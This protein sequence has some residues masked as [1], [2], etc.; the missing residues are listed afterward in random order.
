MNYS[1]FMKHESF[2][3]RMNEEQR[4]EIRVLAG[5]KFTR[6]HIPNPVNN[7]GRWAEIWGWSAVSVWLTLL[8]PRKCV[9]E[10]GP[11]GDRRRDDE[12]KSFSEFRNSLSLSCQED[13]KPALLQ[14]TC[15]KRPPWHCY[16]IV[17]GDP[18][19]NVAGRGLLQQLHHALHGLE[20]PHRG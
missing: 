12:F 3:F 20:D 19:H 1:L 10:H 17:I 4:S 18:Q 2:F 11:A 14:V 8:I 9:W 16:N 15:Y 5:V 13:S 7:V 6:R